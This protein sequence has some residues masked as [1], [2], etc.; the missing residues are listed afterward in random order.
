MRKKAEEDMRRAL[1]QAEELS[2]PK[3]NFVTLVSHEF[4]TPLGIIMSAADILRQYFDRLSSAA[5]RR[6]LAGYP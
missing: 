4:R 1:E 2:L 6:A 5:P 3:T